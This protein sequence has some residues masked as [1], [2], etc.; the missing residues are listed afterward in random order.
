MNMTRITEELKSQLAQL[1]IEH[2]ADLAIFLI[3]SLDDMADE[4]VEAAWDRELAR[5]GEEIRQGRAQGEP[6]DQVF[7]RLRQ[8]SG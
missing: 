5:R 4:G 8:K 1:P 2:R 3:G 7:A 6:A